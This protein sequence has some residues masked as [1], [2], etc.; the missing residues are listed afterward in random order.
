MKQLLFV[1]IAAM[2]FSSCDVVMQHNERVKGNG[3]LAKTTRSINGFTGIDNRGSIDVVISQGDF[4]I[5]VEA[6]ENL[7][8]YIETEVRN[9]V[10]EV[11]FQDNINIS[12]HQDVVVYVTAPTLNSVTTNGSGDIKTEGKIKSSEPVTVYVSGSGNIN[13][14]LNA[15]SVK[16]EIHGSG[17]ITIAGETKDLESDVHGS[18]DI[19]AY[20]LK[21]ENVKSGVHGSGNT[22]VF[23]SVSIDASISGSGNVKYK[24]SPKTVNSKKNGSGE[25][26]NVD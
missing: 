6:E 16:T 9:G 5:E 19:R 4:K 17:N 25:V 8:E 11:S 10:L 21:A 12:T 15:P 23:A 20:E 26:R 18:G 14:D 13:V 22:D 24:G 1:L 7:M 2:L 3:N